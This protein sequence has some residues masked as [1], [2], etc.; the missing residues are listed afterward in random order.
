MKKCQCIIR[1]GSR[2]GEVCGN[3]VKPDQE[4][5]GHHSRNGGK[6]ARVYS[7]VN[8]SLRKSRVGVEVETKV[9]TV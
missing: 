9:L 3:R 2:K 4:Y 1:R 6:N 8:R 7:P 5:C